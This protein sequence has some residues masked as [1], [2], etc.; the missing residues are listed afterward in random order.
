MLPF[1]LTGSFL[2][3]AVIIAALIVEAATLDLNAIWFA[4]GGLGGLIVTS[5]GG[6]LHVQLV[7]FVVIS[8][9]LIF[10][11]RPFARRVL[12][13]KGAATNA[14]RIIGQEALVTQ[15]INNTLSQGEIKVFGQLWTARAAD[16][17]EIPA[18]SLV[19]VREIVGVK[20]IVE[21]IP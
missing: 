20:A 15:P 3:V 12:R 7:V 17:G 6:S 18:G 8:A 1:W 13:P 5:V 11:V 2:W 14:D 9:V 4:L 19:R 16:G 10:L 21:K